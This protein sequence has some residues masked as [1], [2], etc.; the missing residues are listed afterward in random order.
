MVKPGQPVASPVAPQ[1]APAARPA[2][3]DGGFSGTQTRNAIRADHA[4]RSGSTGGVGT[5]ELEPGAGWCKTPLLAG[6]GSAAA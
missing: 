2:L 6:G 5:V 4:L 3:W 1:K